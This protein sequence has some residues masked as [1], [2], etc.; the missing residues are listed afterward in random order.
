[1]AAT[2]A[3]RRRFLLTV[4]GAVLLGLALLVAATM[5]VVLP[6]TDIPWRFAP[7][8]AQDF[9]FTEIEDFDRVA[10]RETLS[11][12][13]PD[14]AERRIAAQGFACHP[15]EA[16]RQCRRTVSDGW[17]CQEEWLIDLPI[18][19]DGRTGLPAGRIHADCL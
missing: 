13:A 12:L 3:P 17:L 7:P 10:I 11:G 9:Y 1:M 16:G 8:L 14:E 4:L 5:I 2:P 19:A 18:G 15:A 6:L